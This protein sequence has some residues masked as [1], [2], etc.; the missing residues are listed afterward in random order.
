MRWKNRRRQGAVLLVVLSMLF[1]FVIMVLTFVMVASHYRRSATIYARAEQRD[2]EPDVLAD[3]IL[4]QFLRAPRDGHSPTNG[5]ALL[6]DLYSPGTSF[7][8]QQAWIPAPSSDNAND[9]TNWGTVLVLRIRHLTDANYFRNVAEADYGGRV[10]TV[11]SGAFQ[12]MSTRS[13][14]LRKVFDPNSGQAGREAYL[15]IRMFDMPT[16]PDHETARNSFLY[17]NGNG[18]VV[19][20]VYSGN[21]GFLAGHSVWM[22]GA[23]FAGTGAVGAGNNSGL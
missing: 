10:I 12:S 20:E 22:N 6:Q 13:I 15:V 4:M 2:E 21:L 23:T 5:H 14:H 18:E 17:R 1:M 3:R 8:I 19:G 7:R 9:V 11:Q 16:I